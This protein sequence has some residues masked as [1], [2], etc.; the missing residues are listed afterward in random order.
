MERHSALFG[1]RV[2]ARNG[3]FAGCGQ[4]HGSPIRAARLPAD[5]LDA[6]QA[7]HPLQQIFQARAILQQIFETD[8]VFALRSRTL[9][10]QLQR[11]FDDGHRRF[12]FVR[13][14]AGK[15][16]LLPEGCLQP[17]QGRL[18]GFGERQ[19]SCGSATPERRA[20][21]PILCGNFVRLPWPNREVAP[22]LGERSGSQTRSPGSKQARPGPRPRKLPAS[23][24]RVPN[25]HHDQSNRKRHLGGKRGRG[26]LGA[27][28]NMCLRSWP[29]MAHPAGGFFRGSVSVPSEPGRGERGV[30]GS[31][32][33][34]LIGPAWPPRPRRPAARHIHGRAR[35][36]S[37]LRRWNRRFCGANRKCTLR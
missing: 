22:G 7:Q 10:K 21:F 20:E 35:C 34:R 33:L 25:G 28:S 29:W 31:R 16:A 24:P 26:S 4:V 32:R 15:I 36:G 12:Q 9:Q 14:I 1:H 8:L 37:I 3:R 23:T 30:S 17:R 19:N 13:G 2:N 27:R 5:L 6:R 11:G 18:D